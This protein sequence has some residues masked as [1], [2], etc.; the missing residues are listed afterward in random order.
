MKTFCR[1][2]KNGEG[3]QQGVLMALKCGR[4][5]FHMKWRRATKWCI[6]FF[7]MIILMLVLCAALLR[8]ENGNFYENV[9]SQTLR[10]KF[11]LNAK[12]RN[13]FGLQL[14]SLI[15]ANH[16]LGIFHLNS[17]IHN[18]HELQLT[19]AVIVSHLLF[20]CHTF[21]SKY[22]RVHWWIHD[23]TTNGIC[24]CTRPSVMDSG[25]QNAM[26]NKRAK[27]KWANIEI[28]YERKM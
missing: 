13:V 4:K 25:R 18:A 9:Y 28:F 3:T 16:F 19:G 15:V 17:L 27:K 7:F 2:K 14:R 1:Q 23:K 11:N 24:W 12:K 6:C 20:K 21:L 10:V 26:A 8:P 5:V 22:S